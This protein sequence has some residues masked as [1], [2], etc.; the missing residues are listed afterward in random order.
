MI[1]VVDD[2][3]ELT[4][5]KLV[6]K[7]MDSRYDQYD[8]SLSSVSVVVDDVVVDAVVCVVV[9]LVVMSVVVD[10]VVCV[11]ICCCI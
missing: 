3:N 1:V 2:V 9:L 11:D 8:N 10:D 7:S 5:C 6:F 4:V